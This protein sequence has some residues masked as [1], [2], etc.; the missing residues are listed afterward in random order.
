MFLRE[1]SKGI[2]KY[3]LGNISIIL[4]LLIFCLYV[5]CLPTYMAIIRQ[6]FITSKG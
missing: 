3:A 5:R 6:R 4:G 2:R 1:L